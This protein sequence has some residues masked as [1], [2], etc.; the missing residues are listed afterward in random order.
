MFLTLNRKNTSLK[1]LVAGLAC[2]AT[3][4]H[5]AVTTFSN[6]ANV[7]AG[8]EYNF[9]QYDPGIGLEVSLLGAPVPITGS[10]V[11]FMADESKVFGLSTVGYLA[12]IVYSAK[13]ADL[14]TSLNALTA[15]ISGDVKTIGFYLGSYNHPGAPYSAV[16]TAGGTDYSFSAGLALPATHLAFGFVGFTSPMAITKVI[17]TQPDPYNA[18]DVQKFSTSSVVAVPEPSAYAMFGAG[19]ALFGMIGLRRRRR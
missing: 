9:N 10:G 1:L 6:P 8:T 2:A 19:L 4:S 11:S 18:L 17:F 14:Q 7:V 15:T 12:D 13:T 16:V 3:V 5:A